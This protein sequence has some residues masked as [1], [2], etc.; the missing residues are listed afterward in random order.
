MNKEFACAHYCL[1]AHK[2]VL[3]FPEK[4][5]IGPQISVS[6]CIAVGVTEGNI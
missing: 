5:K 2:S 3:T 1:Q 4:K 6:L